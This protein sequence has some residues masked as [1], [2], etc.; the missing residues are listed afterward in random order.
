MYNGNMA[1]KNDNTEHWA[2]Q[3]EKTLGLWQL[4]LVLLFVKFLPPSFCRACAFIVSF[5]Y[6]CFSKKVRIESRRFFKYVT[7]FTNSKERHSVYKHILS[8]SLTLIEKIETWSGREDTVDIEYQN[9]D[10]YDLVQNLENKKGALLICSHIGNS[11]MLRACACLNKTAVSHQFPIVSITYF[12]VTPYF[13]QIL[14]KINPASNN[15]LISA[16]EINPGTLITLSATIEKGGLVVIAGDRTPVSSNDRTLEFSFL[17]KKASF[18]LGAFLI[19]SLLDAPTYFIFALRKDI[20][21]AT[22]LYRMNVHKSKISFDCGRNER[23]TRI[24]E[25]A[26]NFV[27]YLEEYCTKEPYQW[28]NFYDFWA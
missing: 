25:L 6:F 22:P 7:L 12:S 1:C 24:N 18:P 19:A 17:G 8:F 28:Y 9:D 16:D 4:K 23:K 3:R 2:A 21:L 15:Q 5:F 13:N 10:I 20:S 14:K 26:G 27:S 11:E